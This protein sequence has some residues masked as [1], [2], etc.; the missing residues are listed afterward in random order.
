MKV[1]HV[2]KT[3][4][5]DTFG[6]M[7]ETI[8]QLSMQTAKFGVTNLVITTSSNITKP[9]IVDHEAFQVM[10]FPVT[11]NFASTPF[12]F[13]LLRRFNELT[14]DADLIHY[15]FPWPVADLM[16]MLCRVKIPYIIT[17]QSDIVKQKYLDILYSRIK[18]IF[19]SNARLITVASPQYMQ[20]SKTLSRHLQRCRLMTLG[21]TDQYHDIVDKDKQSYWEQRVG[22]DFFLFIG[23]LRYY[24]GLT[25]LLKAI[26]GTKL[27]VVIVGNGPMW[28]SLHDE[29]SKLGIQNQI[30]FTGSIT[31]E[32]KVYLYSLCRAFV[33]PSHLRS[34]A[35]GISL[36][37]A[38]MYGCC[39]ISCDI[40][41]GTS[42][43]NIHCE[44]GI[45]VP[46]ADHFELKNA[47]N[48][49]QDNSDIALQMGSAARRRYLK[50]FMADRMGKTCMSYYN[51]ALKLR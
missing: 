28:Q 35:F 47:M 19:L 33:F 26:Q 5:P 15:H 23:A 10:R 3:Y 36:L 16:H 29:V 22:R 46:P 41:T 2:N 12:S 20:S 48:Y 6:G 14:A 17:Y 44:T 39:L 21:L 34:E 40:S 11:F 18:H 24:K 45:V 51:Y 50:H 1:I 43:I 7:E 25:Y 49:L 30:I 38:A 31:N 4:Y 13:Q 32:E 37:E 8:R 42:Y 9:E 27:R